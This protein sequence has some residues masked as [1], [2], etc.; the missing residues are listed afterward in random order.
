MWVYTIC[1]LKM[2]IMYSRGLLKI[3]STIHPLKISVAGTVDVV[4]SMAIHA[5]R[6]DDVFD[7]VKSKYDILHT[8]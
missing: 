2:G 8:P 1:V 3:T 4:L 7:D 5:N 6:Y